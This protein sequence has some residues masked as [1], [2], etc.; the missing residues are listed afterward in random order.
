MHSLLLSLALLPAAQASASDRN[1]VKAEKA[2]AKEDYEKALKKCSKALDQD[3]GNSR[4]A[5]VCGTVLYLWG[6]ASGDEELA[7]TG[8]SL[9]EGVALSSPDQPFLELYRQVRGGAMM[10]APNFPCEDAES[11]AWNQAEEAFVRNDLATART[12]YQVAAQGCENPTLWT[13]YGDTFFA[14]Q[15]YTQAFQAYEHALQIDPFHWPALR[16]MGDGYI[17]QNKTETGYRWVAK[18][19][20]ANPVYEYAWIYLDDVLDPRVK[21]VRGTTLPVVESGMVVVDPVGGLPPFTG[22]VRMIY[23]LGM[24]APLN[25]GATGHERVV[26]AL[27]MSLSFVEEKGQ[28]EE[29]GMALWALLAEARDAGHFEQ[30]VYILLLNEAMVPAFTDYREDNMESLTDYVM[31]LLVR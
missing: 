31:S 18:S 16:F 1:T 15:D 29:P 5:A 3:S 21:Q 12:H 30:A 19:L 9:M 27:G 10:Q 4:A 28:L 22:E 8:S 2:F 11:A 17:K 23:Q 25:E 13:Y 6:A 7:R 24:Q 20:A 14:E 26:K